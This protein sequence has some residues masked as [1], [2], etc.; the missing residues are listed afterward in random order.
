MVTLFWIV[1]VGWLMWKAG[2]IY[3]RAEIERSA[4]RETPLRDH[5]TSPAQWRRE[6]E[7]ITRGR[8]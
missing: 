6:V 7:Q 4:P 5:G 1:V 2:R 3:E 8:R